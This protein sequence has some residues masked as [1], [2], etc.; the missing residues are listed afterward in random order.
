MKFGLKVLIIDDDEVFH[1][2]H[3]KILIASGFAGQ[4]KCAF[5]GKEGLDV[6]LKDI[7]SAMPPQLV[8][9]DLQMPVFNGFDFLEAL[10]GLRF[11][12]REDLFVSVLS[13]SNNRADCER[14]LLLGANAYLQ[15]PLSIFELNNAMR[16]P[17]LDIDKSEGVK[18]HL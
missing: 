14:A 8:L 12:A 16:R 9:L 18:K 17:D 7:A 3:S 13:S 5:N 4:V 1:M 6:L 11:D 2:V 15:K 10:R